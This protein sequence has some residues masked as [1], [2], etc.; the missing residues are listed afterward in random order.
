MAK[1]YSFALVDNTTFDGKDIIDF[2][3]KALLEKGARSTF[4]PIVGV[5]SKIKL[6][7]YDAGN[8]I[9]EAG[10]AWSPAG[11]GTL[12]QKDFEVCAFDIQL[13]LCETTFENNF[14]SVLLR[15]GHNT[16]QV[17]PSEFVNYMIG[18]VGDKIQNDLEIATWQGDTATAS[19]PLSICDGLIKKFGAT[20]SGVNST[21]SGTVSASTVLGHMVAAYNLVPQEILNESDLTIYVSTAVFRAY[22]NAVSAGSPLAYY[23]G[24]LKD[25]NFHGINIVVSKGLPAGDFVIGR[26]SNFVALTDLMN[27]EET[28][29]VIP[30]RAT[31]GT[32]TVR[33]AGGFKFGVDFK[34]GE[35]IVYFNG[36]V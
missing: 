11:E 15:D 6:P 35:E 2:Y 28:L 10:C 25:L 1:K 26:A 30:Q 29:D 32:R 5:K 20:G 13:E 4:Q 27:D 9:K 31:A 24:G 33:V 21:L 36:T 23:N 3:S 12:S 17:A 8:I 14:L 7:R 18:Q 19:Y 22:V 16:G 34:I